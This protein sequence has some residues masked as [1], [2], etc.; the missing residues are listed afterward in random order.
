[1]QTWARL[2][3]IIFYDAE[4]FANKFFVQ[5]V[6]MFVIRFRTGAAEEDPSVAHAIKFISFDILN[7]SLWDTVE[8]NLETTR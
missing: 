2:K 1:M 3:I 8:G 5:V 6:V 7:V 4:G